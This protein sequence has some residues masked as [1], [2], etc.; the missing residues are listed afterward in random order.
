MTLKNSEIQV[1]AKRYASAL[2]ESANGK[3][4][5]VDGVAKEL[6]DLLD[7]SKSNDEFSKLVN[8]PLFSKEDKISA[9]KEISK[10]SKLSDQTTNLI[11]ILVENSR[12]PI[13]PQIC[14]A[15]KSI[16]MEDKGF[17]KAEV[18]SARKLKSTEIKKITDSIS[19]TTGKK[20]ECENLIDESIIGGLRVKI[21][22]K[23]ID[24]SISGRLERL[25]LDLAS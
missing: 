10:K 19:K 14:M 5:V 18:V 20:V 11:L 2:F 9:L 24:N 15:F 6:E 12:L 17:V 25:K 13:L 23:L 7:F 16:V 3:A 4:S 8:S 22:S 1:L 21:G